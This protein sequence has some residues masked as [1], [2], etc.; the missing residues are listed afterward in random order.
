MYIYVYLQH[1]LTSPDADTFEILQKE[2]VSRLD[3]GQGETI[4]EVGGG[5]QSCL[6]TVHVC[7]VYVTPF[8]FHSSI[9][10]LLV[11]MYFHL[12]T[13]GAYTATCICKLSLLPNTRKSPALLPPPPPPPLHL[14]VRVC[15]GSYM[16][17]PVACKL[18]YH[19]SC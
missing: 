8:F 11:Y 6:Y 7:G 16:C 1:Q 2:L 10:Y 19:P 5:G 17:N 18:R 14:L 15:M 12:H 9:C 13:S 4:Y 3:E